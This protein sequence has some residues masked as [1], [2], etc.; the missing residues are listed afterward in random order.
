MNKKTGKRRGRK[1]RTENK[2]NQITLVD[3]QRGPKHNVQDSVFTS[4][5]KKPENILQL[6]Q[7]LF[8]DEKIELSDISHINEANVFM[9]GPYNDLS[10]LVK[11]KK[12]VMVEAQTTWSLNII[13]RFI[14]YSAQKLEE[15]LIENEGKD[16]LYRTKTVPIPK[17][18]YF[19]IYT[20]DK[21]D[22]LE[23]TYTLADITGEDNKMGYE[24][25]VIT[26]AP[27]GT[28]LK[29][30][31]E[32][33]WLERKYTKGKHKDKEAYREALNKA[34]DEAIERGILEAY[35]R[36]HREEVIMGYLDLFDQEELDRAREER[37]AKLE[38]KNDEIKAEAKARA[39]EAEAR[40]NEAETRADEAEARMI[41]AEA[42]IAELKA[43]L[44]ELKKKIG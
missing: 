12:Y 22:D 27:D 29:E 41:E 36:A 44:E 5:F 33:I 26:D 13:I 6:Y 25:R 17:F 20:G 14:P 11:N 24:I 30:F 43:R 2:K 19:V 38:R 3:K 32:F 23:D 18:A 34:I 1:R 4:L 40:V 8:P 7:T 31:L 15:W 9:A 42:E 39:D 10:F 21:R 35:L 28:L 16:A 37:I